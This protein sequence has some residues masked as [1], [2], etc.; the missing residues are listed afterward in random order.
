MAFDSVVYRKVLGQFATG[1]TLITTK[2]DGGPW[3]MTAN[4]FTSI[5]LNPPIVMVAVT[6]GLTTNAAIK[7]NQAFAVNILASDQTE[8]AKRFGGRNRPPDPFADVKLHMGESGSPLI[9]GCLAYV[10]CQLLDHTDQGD[11][12]VFF[13]EVVDMAIEERGDPLLYYNS[14]YARIEPTNRKE[15]TA[16]GVHNG[17]LIFFDWEMGEY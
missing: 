13:G 16:D 10:D 14:G 4:S 1:V 15:R 6:H 7:E 17:K 11:H 8:L 2:V 9:D 3:A 5:S 12:T